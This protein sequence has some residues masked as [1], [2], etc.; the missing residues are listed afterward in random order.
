M[1]RDLEKW[2]NSLKNMECKKHHNTSS[3]FGKSSFSMNTSLKR[4][5]NTSKGSRAF[6]ETTRDFDALICH[7]ASYGAE[8]W[9]WKAVGSCGTLSIQGIFQSI[10]E[11]WVGVAGKINYMLFISWEI[12]KGKGLTLKFT[13]TTHVMVTFWIYMNIELTINEIPYLG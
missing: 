9:T 13:A 6:H 4:Y 5:Y 8:G 7:S 11:R 2:N 3:R 1:F 12:W 10:S